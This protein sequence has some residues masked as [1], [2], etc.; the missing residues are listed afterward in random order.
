[1]VLL[2]SIKI[3][4]LSYSR[5]LYGHISYTKRQWLSVCFDKKAIPIYAAYVLLV[6][7]RERSLT[8]SQRFYDIKISE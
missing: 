2:K 1:M 8:L 6:L 3:I 4:Y 7:V 5:C